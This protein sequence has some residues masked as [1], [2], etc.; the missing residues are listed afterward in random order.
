MTEKDV[1]KQIE[2]RE[3]MIKLV[4][5]SVVKGKINLHQGEAIVDR[6][7]EVFTK[8]DEPFLVVFDATFEG[9]SGRV[10]ILNKRNMIWVAPLDETKKSLP[11]GLK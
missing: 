2:A 9:K 8:R 7:S 3:V 6:V 4:D 5:G 11:F 1:P 10:L